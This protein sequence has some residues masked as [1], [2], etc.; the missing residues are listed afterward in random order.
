L[1]RFSLDSLANEADRRI[2]LLGMRTLWA[3]ST[4]LPASDIDSMSLER[5][6]P[7]SLFVF[8]DMW[9][10]SKPLGLITSA[11]TGLFSVFVSLLAEPLPVVL[12]S[13][14]LAALTVG[15]LLLVMRVG[16]TEGLATETLLRVPPPPRE[17]KADGVVEPTELLR[18][19]DG[20]HLASD[21]FS[22]ARPCRRGKK[23][24]SITNF[25]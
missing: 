3:S 10:S 11:V 22:I 15:T 20:M 5:L 25:L 1:G 2:K 17:L 7:L 12:A 21:A 16:E 19:I 8:A 23:E 18:Y 4:V 14:S 6:F 24:T 9:V 13:W